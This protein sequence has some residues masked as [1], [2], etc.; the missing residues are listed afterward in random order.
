MIAPT[1][2]AFGLLTTTGVFSLFSHSLHNNLPAIGATIIGSLLPDIDSPRSSLGRLVPF[3]SV[4]IE[5]RWGHRTVTHCLLAVAVLAVVLSPLLFF[6]GTMYAALLI[7]YASHLIPADCATKSG[8]PLFY[9]HPAQ[10]V[11]PGNDRFRIQTGSMAEW[12]LLAVL[13][14]MLAAVFPISQMGGIWRVLRYLS[15]TQSMAYNDFREATTETIL[16]FKGHLRETRQPVSGEALILHATKSRFIIVLNGQTLS[17]GETG[18]ILPDRS[19]VRA[20][21]HTIRIDT[22]IVR[23]DDMDTILINIP[24]NAFISGRLESAV[25]FTAHADDKLPQLRHQCIQISDHKLNFNYAPK[26]VV[27]LL[28]PHRKVDPDRITQ[29]QQ[30]IQDLRLELDALSITRPPVHYLRL[31]EIQAELHEKERQFADLQDTVVV[32][33]GILSI[34]IPSKEEP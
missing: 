20:T 8:C 5:R 11:L 18:D 3:I 2:V 10:C 25:S 14:T 29:L 4:P 21:G 32:F 26:A 27:S 30:N 31:R 28:H 16:N 34:R 13:I 9:P 22:L 19:R 23:D 6:Q 33:S 12:G 17:Y 15:A 24:I 1:H 7:G